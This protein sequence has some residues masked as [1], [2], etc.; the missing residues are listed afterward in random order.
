MATA[1]RAF[2]TLRNFLKFPERPPSLPWPTANQMTKP[3]QA[4]ARL[5]NHN[6]SPH[7]I[8]NA[9]RCQLSFAGNPSTESAPRP[10]SLLT[11]NTLF[12][13]GPLSATTLHHFSAP[14]LAH[15]HLHHEQHEWQIPPFGDFLSRPGCTLRSLTIADVLVR[16]PALL[17]LFPLLPSLEALSLRSLRPHALLDSALRTLTLSPGAPPLMPALGSLT[18]SGSYLFSTPALLT[19]L[20]SRAAPSGFQRVDLLMNHRQF[21]AEDLRRLRALHGVNVRLN[22]VSGDK[23]V[24][25]VK[26]I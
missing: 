19:L 20:E 6:L 7:L 25:F 5:M 24:A 8:Y 13:R 16:A 2:K 4:I 26:V 11:A 22:L 17:K 21:S 23:N 18:L 10:G 14:A 9:L 12:L 15:L 3:N 1:A